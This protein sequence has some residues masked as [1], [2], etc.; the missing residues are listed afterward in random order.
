MI[1]QPQSEID[2]AEAELRRGIGSA[3]IG[4]AA[5]LLVG[6][7]VAGVIVMVIVAVGMAS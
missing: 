7:M 6:I 4:I 3:A 1:D 5:A 2:Q